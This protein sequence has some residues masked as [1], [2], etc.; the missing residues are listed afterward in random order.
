MRQV[1]DRA[2]HVLRSQLLAENALTLI[3]TSC[4]FCSRRCA[5]TRISSRPARGLAERSE[6]CRDEA[7][8]D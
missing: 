2:A 7:G 1:V 8:G 3:G 5:V 4:R 6:W